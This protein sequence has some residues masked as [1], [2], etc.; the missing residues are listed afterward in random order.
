[1]HLI[2]KT[3]SLELKAE[4]YSELYGL[5]RQNNANEALTYLFKELEVQ[6]I[7]NDP[8]EIAQ[9][10]SQIGWCYV[11]E[12]QNL[13]SAKIYLEKA[14][15]LGLEINDSIRIA[16]SLTFLG[17]MNQRKGYYKT[18]LDYYYKSLTY[19]EAMKDH[20]G[21]SYSYNLI[22]K[23]L[24]LQEQYDKSLEFHFKSLKEKKKA[25]VN[26][27]IAL[28]YRNIGAVYLQTDKYEKA[29]EYF[30]KALELQKANKQRKAMAVC[31]NGL[32][33]AYLKLDNIATSIQYF[34][35]SLSISGVQK[36]TFQ[37]SNSLMGLAKCQIA[38]NN[39]DRAEDY[40]IQ[41]LSFSKLDAFRNNR[42]KAYQ[43]LSEIYKLQGKNEAAL[44]AY[45]HYTALKDS[46][47]NVQTLT[48]IAE[49]EGIYNTEK[50]EREIDNLK[51]NQE[52]LKQEQRFKNLIIYASIIFIGLILLFFFFRNRARKNRFQQQLTLK[53]QE[54]EITQL[55]LEGEETKNKHYV[56]ELNNFMQL[57]I[58]KNNQIKDLQERLET[59]PAQQEEDANYKENIQ[60]LYNTTILTDD[61]WKTFR[62]IFEQVH[63][64][65][66]TNLV[67]HNSS[68][69]QGD[70]KLAALLRLNL[71]N[72]EISSILGI[73][74]ESVRKNKYR[75]RKKL[76]FDT[77]AQLQDFINN[78]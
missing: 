74:P 38:Q 12:V 10:Y 50:K 34:E 44:T 28:S 4:Y 69:S 11:A 29:I 42:K 24:Q 72:F 1:M 21:M 60:Q 64:N 77:D 13:D 22:G 16:K 9:T 30:N 76:A 25:N 17:F 7:I 3:D 32:G 5:H 23:T 67:Q 49:L 57:M 40:A 59:F 8:S 51:Q 61:D 66:I 47:I 27:D 68:I 63:P 73:S 65:F 46:L 58:S 62:V 31:Y 41:V 78:I 15:N 18:A 2:Q 6:N 14:Y 33:N 71:S 52:I 75:I 45:E 48:Q 37:R 26:S 53:E 70:L 56:T 43:L 19:K 36:N 54:N 20:S 35:Q 55:K 39:L